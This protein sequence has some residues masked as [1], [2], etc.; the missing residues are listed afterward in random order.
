MFLCVC[1]S[2]FDVVVSDLCLYSICL[3]FV[4]FF[5][6]ILFVFLNRTNANLRTRIYEMVD[7]LISVSRFFNNSFGFDTEKPSLSHLNLWQINNFFLLSKFYMFLFFFGQLCLYQS[8]CSADQNADA[9]TL[10]S[11]LQSGHTLWFRS[12]FFTR[13]CCFAMQ[14]LTEFAYEYLDLFEN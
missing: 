1:V 13:I 2:F 6:F 5:F 3:F 7:R 10:S 12:L 11:R 4:G 14:F 9:F 8:I